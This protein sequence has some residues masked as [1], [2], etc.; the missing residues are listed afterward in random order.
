MRIPARGQQD[1][2]CRRMRHAGRPGK[3]GQ[4]RL[5]PDCPAR[6]A[7]PCHGSEPRGTGIL[8]PGR[9]RAV[10]QCAVAHQEA[11]V[12]LSGYTVPGVVEDME[13]A[14][15]AL[16]YD[17]INLYSLSF[18]TRIAQIYAYMHPDSLHRLLAI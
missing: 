12:D 15:I 16:R 5:A 14:R 17:R 3:L 8:S 10:K 11:G 4:S 6:C 13:A 7:H 18:G 9:S 1:K 2:L